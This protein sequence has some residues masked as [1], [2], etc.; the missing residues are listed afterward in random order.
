MTQWNR[1]IAGHL[2]YKTPPEPGTILGPIW[3]GE[4]AVV[5]G[6]E[7]DGRTALS[8]AQADELNEAA[9]RQKEDGEA[10]R[11]LTEIGKRRLDL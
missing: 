1:P 9:R 5:L 4:Y 7:E 6:Q 3:T 8:Y 10:A 11:S 2:R